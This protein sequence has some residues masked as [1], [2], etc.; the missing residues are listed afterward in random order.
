[1]MLLNSPKAGGRQCANGD[2]DLCRRLRVQLDCE[3][4]PRA[5]QSEAQ[6]E[7]GTNGL[8]NEGVQGAAVKTGLLTDG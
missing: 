4:A 3:N 8:H 7:V 1:M 5:M 6:H 2:D